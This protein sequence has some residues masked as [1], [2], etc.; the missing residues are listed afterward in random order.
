VRIVFQ[1]GV[2]WE[3]W[4][5]RS[6]ATG[7][8][9]AQEAVIEL[10]R[11]FAAMRHD[12]LVRNRC[13][14][15]EGVHEGV[16]YEDER[17][18]PIADCDILVC[19]R[20]PDLCAQSRAVHA[21]RRYLW[22]QDVVDE[23]RVMARV[24]DFDR[25]IVLSAFNRTLYPSLT[26]A[27]IF[28]SSNGIDPSHFAGD[29]PRDPHRLIY[30]SEYSRGLGTLLDAWPEIRRE[31]PDATLTICYGWQTLRHY[32]PIRHLLFRARAEMRMRA[33]GIRHLGRIGHRDV[34]REMLSAGV[35]AYPCSFPETS[36]LTA[37]KAQAAGAVPAVT[38]CGGLDETV[39]FGFKV[40]HRPDRWARRAWLDGLLDLLRHPEQQEA[41]RAEMRPAAASRF[42]WDRI[43]AAWDEEFRRT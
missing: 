3:P 8:G 25:L 43:A 1:C 35:W 6:A 42:G 23:A 22:L 36:C 41:I 19:W 14:S 20:N 4:S 31:V 17:G 10:A 7:S 5:P 9:G 32:R 34:A 37:M 21:G 30:A 11:R 13:G 33:P 12:V 2:S 15:D 26:D 28:R 18:Q 40:A 29:A 16:R 39:Q 24:A 27:R 38:T